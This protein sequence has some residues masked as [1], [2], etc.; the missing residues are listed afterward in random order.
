MVYSTVPW[1]KECGFANVSGGKWTH[2][3]VSF[4]LEMNKL[5]SAEFVA[6]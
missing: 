4:I 1:Y 2:L 5:V 6:K 3:N